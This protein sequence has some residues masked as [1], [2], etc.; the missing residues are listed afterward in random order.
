[1]LC[2]AAGKDAYIN[3][4]IIDGTVYMP[5]SILAFGQM[6]KGITEGCRTTHGCTAF[7]HEGD[8]VDMACKEVKYADARCSALICT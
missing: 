2:A 3:D 1:M 8:A 5:V 6:R 4:H 7:S